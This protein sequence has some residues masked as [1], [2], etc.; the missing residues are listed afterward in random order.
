MGNM[1]APIGAEVHV[2]VYVNEYGKFV[3]THLTPEGAL[4]AKAGYARDEWE[5]LSADHP[6]LPTEPPEDD[7]EAAEAYFSRR[8]GEWAD[9]SACKLEA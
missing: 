1:V 9:I 5:A 3:T 6:D 2:V 4:K 7:N 8:L